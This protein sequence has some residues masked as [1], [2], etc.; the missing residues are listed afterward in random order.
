M[1]EQTVK[2]D[3]LIIE[4]PIPLAM[5]KDEVIN[6]INETLEEKNWSINDLA[7]G[8]EVEVFLEWKS[9]IEQIVWDYRWVGWEVFHY[10]HGKREYLSFTNPKKKLFNSR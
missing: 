5:T 4:V 7:D 2:V 3:D 1:T 6:L 8:R 9:F 10:L